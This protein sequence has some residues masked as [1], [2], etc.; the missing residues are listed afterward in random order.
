MCIL[1]YVWPRIMAAYRW[2]ESSAV[3]E[4]RGGGRKEEEKPD[5]DFQGTEVTGRRGCA[6]SSNAARRVKNERRELFIRTLLAV[7][8]SLAPLYFSPWFVVIV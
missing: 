1:L 3:R 4:R 2:L 5:P 6:E 8:L 7:H